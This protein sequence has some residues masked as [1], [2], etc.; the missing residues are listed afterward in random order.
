MI[1]PELSHPGPALGRVFHWLGRLYLRLTRWEVEGAMPDRAKAVFLIAPHTSNW[2]M[3]VMTAAAWLF[4]VKPSWLGKRSLFRWPL[5]GLMRWFGGLPIDR[6][7]SR[8]TVEQVAALFE[9]HERLYLGIAPSGTRSRTDHWR[10]GFYYIA[11]A[12]G[13]PIVCAFADYGRRV[14]GIGPLLEPTG[15]IGT[16]MEVLR[17]FYAGI[18]GRYPEHQSAVRLRDAP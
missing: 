3:P 10:S 9:Q 8:N 4:R 1:G 16:D 2:D 7:G 17:E 6:D 15:D 14:C 5:G 12:A 13:V 18:E 11:L